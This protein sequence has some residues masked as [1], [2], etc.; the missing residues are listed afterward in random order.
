MKLHLMNAAGVTLVT[1]FDEQLDALEIQAIRAA[2]NP[3]SKALHYA[4][5]RN[6]SDLSGFYPKRRDGNPLVLEGLNDG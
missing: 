5:V 1:R 2:K 4:K 3:I 6:G